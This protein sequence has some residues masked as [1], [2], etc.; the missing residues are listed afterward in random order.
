MWAAGAESLHPSLADAHLQFLDAIFNREIA[1]IVEALRTALL[2]EVYGFNIE[3]VAGHRQLTLK[4]RG[5]GVEDESIK[6]IRQIAQQ[7][8]LRAATKTPFVHVLG[9]PCRPFKDTAH[10]GFRAVLGSVQYSPDLCWNFVAGDGCPWG[11]TCRWVHPGSMLSLDVSVEETARE[12]ESGVDCLLS[13]LLSPDRGFALSEDVHQPS[14]LDLLQLPDSSDLAGIEERSATDSHLPASRT[15]T[16]RT[17]SPEHGAGTDSDANDATGVSRGAT[18][19]GAL[20]SSSCSTA[21]PN[22][23]DSNCSSL[24]GSLHEASSASSSSIRLRSSGQASLPQQTKVGSG[25]VSARPRTSDRRWVQ[26]YLACNSQHVRNGRSDGRADLTDQ[27]SRRAAAAG[28]A[29]SS[30]LWGA[31]CGRVVAPTTTEERVVVTAATICAALIFSCWL[32]SHWLGAVVRGC[33]TAWLVASERSPV[34]L[35][36]FSKP[37]HELPAAESE[38]RG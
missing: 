13:A 28:G 22:D 31:S 23:S 26:R 10:G 34:R 36:L 5:S 7:A 11:E 33:S 15:T 38:D 24:Q 18:S 8:L 9:D 21:V 3:L 6:Q 35:W 29:S 25:E 4:V 1:N 2:Q 12:E 30:L 19:R 17:A 37:A 27:P 20:S 16:P 14:L 32:G